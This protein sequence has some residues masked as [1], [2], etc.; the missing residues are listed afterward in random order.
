MNWIAMEILRRLQRHMNTKQ[1]TEHEFIKFSTN[2]A[3]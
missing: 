3:R 2:K 1:N